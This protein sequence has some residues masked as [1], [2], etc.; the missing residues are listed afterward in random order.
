MVTG[1]LYCAHCG[2]RID[3]PY[4][5]RRRY[6]S[7]T[8]R[9]AAW[10]ARRSPVIW[11]DTPETP[12]VALEDAMDASLAGLVPPMR[13]APLDDQVVRAILEARGIAG[14][15]RRLGVEVQPK[16]AWRCSGVGKAVHAALDEFFGKDME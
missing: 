8:C 12:S 16:L 13:A 3:P 6:C 2:A 9:N 15:F 14:A 7:I 4:T 1:P 11:E 10:R 5:S